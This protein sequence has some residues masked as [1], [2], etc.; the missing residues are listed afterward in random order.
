MEKRRDIHHIMKGIFITLLTAAMCCTCA[1]ARGNA[2]DLND[3]LTSTTRVLMLENGKVSV[4]KPIDPDVRD[5]ILSFYY[6]QFRHSQDPGAPAFLFMSKEQNIM[7]G[8]GGTVRMRGWYDWGGAVPGNGFFPYLISVTPDPTND[9]KLGTTP[10]GTC[11]YFRLLGENRVLGH[12]E[13]YIEANFNGWEG[14]DFRLKKA[15][16]VIRDFTVGY[17]SSTF[18]DPSAAPPTVDAAG[19]NNKLDHATVLVRYMPRI[20]RNVLAAASVETPDT[21]LS[22]DKVSTQTRS[23]YIP[24]FAAFVQ[25]DWGRYNSE[26]IRLSALY[27]SLPYRDLVAGKNYN[28]AGWAVQLSSVSHPVDPLT[29][30]LTANYGAGYAGMGGDLVIGKYDLIP[31]PYLPGRLYAPRSFGWCVGV[32]YNIRHNLFVSAMGSQT[33]FLPSES[34]NPDEYKYGLMG[35]V[36]VFWNPIPRVQFGAEFDIGERRNFS[37]DHRYAR[38][39]GL[40]GQLTF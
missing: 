13:A 17:A 12:F 22:I 37:G 27:R 2:D 38:R 23:S 39:V 16:A 4:S 25:Y 18:S 7:M 19:P 3:S 5:K 32:Q 11:L 30:Y 33:R 31:H 40:M 15:Y 26:H 1:N 28:P 10:A 35:V 21:Y 34:I 36:N 14:R 8:I 29:L 20:S 6:N 9:K 24:D